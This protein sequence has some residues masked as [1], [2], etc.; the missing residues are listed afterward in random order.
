MAKVGFVSGDKKLGSVA[1]QRK[2]IGPVDIELLPD[3]EDLLLSGYAVRENDTLVIAHARAL[4]RY[5]RG[6]AL[7]EERLRWFASMNVSVQIGEEG[8]AQ[9]YADAEKIA[10]FH[11]AA[12]EPTGI[13]TPKQ[14]KNP[15]RPSTYVEP[16]GDKLVMAKEWYAG[17]LHTNDVGKLVGQMMGTKAVSRATMHAWWGPRPKCEGRVRKPRSDKK[18]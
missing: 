9:I 13:A 17:P 12:L 3:E 11:A 15:G 18:S 1:D 2:R 7:R 5:K 14:K 6:F 4:G 8:I 16:E 10:A